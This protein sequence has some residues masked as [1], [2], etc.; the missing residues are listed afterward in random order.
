MRTK[1]GDNVA[2][3]SVV[4]DILLDRQ[5]VTVTVKGHSM[6]PFFRSGSTVTVRPI[7]AEDFK[8]YAVVFADAGDHF[9]I[10]RII[11]V[12]DN[13]VTLL[14]DG[15]TVGTET[16][17]KDK[18]YGIIDCSPTHIFFAKIWFRLRPI[19]RYPLALLR[20]IM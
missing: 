13:S 11:S 12:N 5:S 14:G 2:I 20:R 1:S 10:H 17:T 8:K 3:F 15:N 6:L 9:V 7:E 18:V 4:R 19:R 16:M